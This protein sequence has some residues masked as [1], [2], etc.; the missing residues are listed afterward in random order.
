MNDFNVHLDETDAIN[1]LSLVPC[2]RFRQRELKPH[3]HNSNA[4]CRT[5]QVTPLTFCCFL[6]V[7]ILKEAYFLFDTSE[8]LF[9][10]VFAKMLNL[11]NGSLSISEPFDPVVFWC[12]QGPS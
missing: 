10:L 11:H 3:Q 5:L 9:T 1:T 6:F 7:Y 12:W 4:G 8:S 2:K